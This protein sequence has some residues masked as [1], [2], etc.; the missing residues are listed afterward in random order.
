MS[1]QLTPMQELYQELDKL[2]IDSISVNDVKRMI[3]NYYAPKEQQV[4]EEF[5]NDGMKSDNGYFSD[6]KD[7][8]NTKFKQNEK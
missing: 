3:G 8:Y 7:Y 5:W 1:N 2:Q 6:F 4:I